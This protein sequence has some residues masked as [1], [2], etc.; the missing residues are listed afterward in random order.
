MRNAFI[1]PFFL[2]FFMLPQLIFP[3]QFL[4]SPPKI[5]MDM[6]RVSIASDSLIIMNRDTS[7]ITIKCYMRD[8][9]YRNGKKYFSP[10]GSIDYSASRWITINPLQ[11]T[12]MPY[13]KKVVRV[14]VQKPESTEKH[15]YRSMIFIESIAKPTKYSR[16]FLFNAR[17]G[18]P[19]YVETA[20]KSF[21]GYIASMAVK[22]D[23][24]EIKYVNGSHNRLY[25]N[26]MYS[27]LNNEEKDTVKSDSINN[28]LVLPLDTERIDINIDDI[29]KGDYY[30]YLYIDNGGESVF[31][32]K[33]RFV[34]E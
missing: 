13:E 17:I 29:K 1:V 9:G 3:V 26:G 20:P 30:I 33:K 11:F 16:G 4:V 14:T 5:E 18:V 2:L 21:N 10:K 27:I 6:S 23:K 7:N 31:G 34:K 19:V 8:W 32:G 28:I 24:I 12:L 15:E 22:N 25:L